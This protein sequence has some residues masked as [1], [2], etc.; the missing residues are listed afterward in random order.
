MAPRT[1]QHR[2]IVIIG[3][4]FAEGFGDYVTIGQVAGMA[5]SLSSSIAQEAK[6]KMTW[7]VLNLGRSGTGTADWLPSGDLFKGIFEHKA[8][9]D[10][11]IV[12]ICLGANDCRPG[13][14]HFSPTDTVQNL[15]KICTALRENGKRVAVSTLLCAQENI[16]QSSDE[17]AWNDET[18]KLL[19][20]YFMETKNESNPVMPG[21]ALNAPKLVAR[22]QYYA[23]DGMHFNS[24][25]Y[26]ML[27]RE[28]K[29]ALFSHIKA[30][31]W[32]EFKSL[33]SADKEYMADLK[34]QLS[35][36]LGKKGK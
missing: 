32:D 24:A 21:P 29:E 16:S 28:A 12:A 25:G 26:K 19:K 33:L 31:E 6:V 23:F 22:S 7:K 18:N 1:N 30:V 5:S 15:K 17:Q 4:G 3:D 8:Y 35:K 27:G 13:P 34:D 14:K 36:P 10:T 2:K 9:S 20:Q 11:D